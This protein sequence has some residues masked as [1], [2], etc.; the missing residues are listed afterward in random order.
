MDISF[1]AR[2]FKSSIAGLT[3]FALLTSLVSFS[4]IASAAFTDGPHWADPYVDELVDL[5]VVTGYANGSFGYNDKVTRAQYAKM[6]VL[7]FLG[8][9]MLVDTASYDSG[10]TD[11]LGDWSDVYIET[12]HKYGLINGLSDAQGNPL[13]LFDPNG[14]V[15]RAAAVKITVSA[16]GLDLNVYEDTPFTDVPSSHWGAPYIE[17]AYWYSIVD[18][19]TATTFDPEGQITRGEAAKVLVNGMSP[20]MR[21]S[22]E[23]PVTTSEATLKVE[24]SDETPEGETIP[25]RSTSVEMASFDLTAMNDDAVLEDI[26][27]HHFGVSSMYSGHSVY[28][29]H[30]TDRLTSGRSV[31]S[32]TNEVV[33]TNVNLDIAEGDTETITVRMDVSG[34]ATLVEKEVGFE[35]EN[36]SDVTTNAMDVS[37]TFPVKAEK[38]TIATEQAGTVTIEKNGTITDPN[39]GDQGVTIAKFTIDAAT[40]AAALNELGLYIT[41]S[42]AADDVQDL[43]LYVSGETDPIAMV[44]GVDSQDVARFIIEGDFDSEDDE[45]GDDEGYCIEKG[46]SKS[47]WVKANLNTGRTDDTLK[48]YVDET[49]DVVALGSK[50]HFGMQVDIDNTDG[51]DGS[52]CTA[53]SGKCSYSELQGGD[54]TISKSDLENNDIAVNQQDVVLMEFT[55]TSLT[56]ATLEDFVLKL[57]ASDTDVLVDSTN[58]NLTNIQVN[59]VGGEGWTWGP[60]DSDDLTDS[61]YTTPISSTDTVG[62]YEFDGDVLDLEAG[63]QRTFQVLVDVENDSANLAG[64]TVQASIVIDSSNPVLKD[65]ERDTMTNSEVL[66]PTATFSEETFEIQSS[67]LAIVLDNVVASDTVVTGTNDAELLALAF[68]TGT[69]EDITIE[70]I[71]FRGYIDGNGSGASFTVGVDD[72]T[73]F[74]EV[75]T[76]LNLYEG[77]VAPENKLN[78]TAGGADPT[79][80]VI[81]FEDL[82]W[83]IPAGTSP[84]LIVVGDIS[85]T[86]TY[87][88]DLVK[89]DIADV[90]ADVTA[91]NER[92]T[93]VTGTGDAA[94][95][96]TANSGTRIT[97]SSGGT[98]SVDVP[99]TTTSSQLVVAGSDDNTFAEIEFTATRENME[100]K[101][102]ALLLENG[103]GSDDD[104]IEAVRVRYFTDEDQ[105][106][107]ATTECTATAT[108][109]VYAC[110]GMTMLVPD[111]R[112]FST[113]ASLW[114]DVDLRD[115]TEQADEGDQFNFTLSLATGTNVEFDAEGAMS[116]KDIEASGTNDL[117]ITDVSNGTAV[118]A[119]NATMAAAGTAN[120]TT[121]TIDDGAGAASNSTSKIVA[122]DFITTTGG[123]AST[124]IMYVT[125][126]T[127]TSLT[128]V[129]GVAGTTASANT[130]ED[131]DTINVY[132]TA[133][134]NLDML[135]TNVMQ[136]QASDIDMEA[137][138]SSRTGV[139]ATTEAI[140][141]F[142][143]S[144][145]EMANQAQFRQG[146][147]YPI[148]DNTGWTNSGMAADAAETTNYVSGSGAV[149]LTE[150]SASAT[151]DYSYYD[152]GSTTQFG[153][154]PRV[155]FWI[156]SSAAKAAGDLEFITD[157]ATDLNDSSANEGN[158]S[159]PALTATKWYFVDSAITNNAAAQYFGIN[160][161]A[162][163]DNDATIIV[164][165]VRFYY[166]SINVDL[167]T[168]ADWSAVT[169]TIA[170]LVRDGQQ[171]ADGYLDLDQVTTSR[172]GQI[173]F[174]PVNT[175]GTFKFNAHTTYT[176]QVQMNTATAMTNAAANTETLTARIDLGNLSSNGTVSAGDVRWYDG[177][178]IVT[179]LGVNS[180]DRVE[181]LSSY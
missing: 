57:T 40:E 147:N 91:T 55:I 126:V 156:R 102:V 61:G 39:V 43:E 180:T 87:D 161:A 112:E 176:M 114:V 76:E 58:A 162:N 143:A 97:I 28:L 175:Y 25:A 70:Q 42:V 171:V 165:E 67:S 173:H 75:V 136:L 23:E 132:G 80:G 54:I 37:G 65:G 46:G 169:P 137:V 9:D 158:V 118:D 144:V 163:P 133:D 51:Y 27:L 110:T 113:Q 128:V 41:G 74:A 6:A 115:E 148:D 108:T 98:L 86:T 146:K 62:Y 73:T 26:T 111:N 56:E 79:S 123:T 106:E 1:V 69:A 18:G 11:L 49:V 30:G 36:A 140:L 105:T 4:G 48:V 150:D 85:N 127:T 164:D 89:V 7:A 33:F 178:D 10:F 157:T 152:T 170:Y 88:G 121:L 96:G 160:I 2:K 38:F 3:L 32:T 177:E 35:I 34:A 83:D 109:D 47:F 93:T 12:A 72:S 103:D 45:C 149:V 159:I 107:S 104:N 44:D 117:T 50:Y 71:D 13:G 60:I 21:D 155:S 77:S 16:A 130:V 141:T 14:K 151:T 68:V 24:L 15:T 19:K 138:A 131:N 22:E 94:N 66:V 5:G 78:T 64:E 63:D 59:E 168:N 81:S 84:K 116:G 174:V 134:T 20:V 82:E 53:A 172:T 154:Y 120:S 100:V 101:R 8:E 166:D 153:A 92:G 17:A 179:F 95:G 52:S 99:T 167:T 124:E 145:P 90:S 135:E 125:A 129:R 29:Y 181:T 139:Q 119:G 142:T 122:G 31:N